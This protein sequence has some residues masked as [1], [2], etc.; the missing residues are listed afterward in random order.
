[1]PQSGISPER[2]PHDRRRRQT[3]GQPTHHWQA[4]EA[5]EADRIVRSDGEAEAVKAGRKV[6]IGRGCLRAG[7]ELPRIAS[8]DG[9]VPSAN[10]RLYARHCF[11]S[12]SPSGRAVDKAS[13]VC[14]RGQRG[15]PPCWRDPVPLVA[16]WSR[17]QAAPRFPNGGACSF[18]P[19]LPIAEASFFKGRWIASL[20]SPF[21]FPDKAICRLIAARK[22]RSL[23]PKRRT[24]P[25][26]RRRDHHR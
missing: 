8:A 15:E 1:M 26:S 10:T 9:S 3:L 22:Q 13:L 16:L 6:V 25:S 12:V 2:Q 5:P 21:P 24:P 14:G 11:P 19:R 18:P 17:I 23:K 4:S 7:S 20:A